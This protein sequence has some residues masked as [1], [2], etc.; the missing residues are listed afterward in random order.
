MMSAN[1]NTPG[2]LKITVL[3]EKGYDVIICADD[4]K[5]KTLSRGSKY[6][7]DAFMWPKFGNCSI[8]MRE[9]ITTSILWGYYRKNRLFWGVVLLQVQYLGLA[10]GTNLKFYTSVAKGL[11]LK[12]RKF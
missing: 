3:W 12:A 11:K 7:V 5:N 9:V 4:V 8:S 1:V 2:L 10:L 6:I